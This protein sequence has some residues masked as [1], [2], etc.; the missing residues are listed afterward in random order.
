MAQV[1]AVRRRPPL[2]VRALAAAFG[3]ALT[4][5]SIAVAAPTAPS[6][7]LYGVTSATELEPS[8]YE[9]M[10]RG[11]VRTLRLPLYWP[12][13]EPQPPERPTQVPGTPAQLPQDQRRW[14]PVDAIVEAAARREIRILPF[15]YGTPDWVSGGDPER[16]PIDDAAARRAW[17]DFLGDLVRRY[18]PDGEL[19]DDLAI[20]EPG[21]PY[22]P[23]TDWQIWN[24]ANSPVFFSPKPSPAEYREVVSLASEA[25]RAADPGA[26]IVLGGMFG[27]PTNGIKAWDF[28]ERF[29]AG[30]AGAGTF[31]TYAL[32]PYSPTLRGVAM[33][34]RRLRRAIDAGPNPGA[35][36][37]ITEIG[38]PTDGPA[39]FNLVKSEASQKRLLAR[40]FRLFL[41]RPEWNVAKVVW[42]V[43]R[44]N[45][46]TPGCTVCR[47]SGLFTERLR[48]KPA[49]RKLTQFT[50]GTP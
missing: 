26:G 34:A 36:L 50:G 18:G 14:G 45:D 22:V 15:V 21:L 46:V 43:W 29:H 19:W 10:A 39:G 25:I 31:D 48:P 4:V 23:I 38:W 24:E 9:L 49:W 2:S 17:Q 20:L 37:W 42:F 11:G 7:E 8:E 47:Y 3:I 13:V 16:P 33:Q 44:D 35:Q 28:L 6:P 41:S 40:S 1:R 12:H 27:A 32:H 5:P 30:G